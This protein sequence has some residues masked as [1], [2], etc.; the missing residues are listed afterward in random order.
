MAEGPWAKGKPTIF[1]QFEKK[2]I[3]GSF[4]QPLIKDKMQL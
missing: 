1:Y 2:E 3:V 4:I